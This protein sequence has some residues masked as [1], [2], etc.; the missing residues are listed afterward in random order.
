MLTNE[1]C[2]KPS[3]AEPSSW[4][5]IEEVFAI[6]KEIALYG[7]HYKIVVP[8]IYTWISKDQDT[9]HIIAS[10]NFLHLTND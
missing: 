3:I 8:R 10:S 4:A 1:I 9:C 5:A 6:R 7:G 2:G